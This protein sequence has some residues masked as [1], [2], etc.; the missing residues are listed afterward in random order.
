MSSGRILCHFSAIYSVI[1]MVSVGGE[2]GAA[3]GMEVREGSN[4]PEE[5]FLGRG[6]AELGP[7]VLVRNRAALKRPPPGQA[8]GR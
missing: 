5:F 7:V 1:P 2:H 3:E 6:G 4:H 8:A